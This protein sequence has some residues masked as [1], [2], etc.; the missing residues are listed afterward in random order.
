MA[1]FMVLVLG[2]LELLGAL[3]FHKFTDYSQFLY[4]DI[5]FIC[6]DSLSCSLQVQHKLHKLL[7]SANICISFIDLITCQNMP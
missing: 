1:C 2:K 5:I 7:C 6:Y 4:C 3:P